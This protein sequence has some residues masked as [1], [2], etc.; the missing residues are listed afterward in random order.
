VDV[1]HG[2]VA[3][4]GDPRRFG[5]DVVCVATGLAV[6]EDA[7][8]AR[9]RGEGGG[10]LRRQR[11]RADGEEGEEARRDPR[12]AARDPPSPDRAARRAA[13]RATRQPGACSPSAP[14]GKGYSYPAIRTW[15]RRYGVRAV[16]PERR[17]QVARRAH[18]PGRKPRFDRA[19][20]RRRHVIENCVGW[21]K[22]ARGVATRFEKLAIH[23]LGLLKL[24]MI[25]MLLHRPAPLS[26][27]P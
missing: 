4:E 18:R 24:G 12:R 7:Q 5:A 3:D 16:I 25:R 19:T 8:F 17:D 13:A 1:G 2:T 20:Y 27:E 15:L 26:D 21:L 14:S 22:E 10:L 6:E 23:Y 9:A 11:R